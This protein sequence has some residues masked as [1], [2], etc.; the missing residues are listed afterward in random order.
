VRSTGYA[1]DARRTY[2]THQVCNQTCNQT[3]RTLV[4]ARKSQGRQK[5]FRAVWLAATLT[6]E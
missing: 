5:V 2:R 3:G 1:R 6:P 4:V